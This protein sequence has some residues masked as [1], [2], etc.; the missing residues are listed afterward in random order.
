RR[1]SRIQGGCPAWRNRTV[2]V[3]VRS[4]ALSEA[5]MNQENPPCDEAGPD[6]GKPESRLEARLERMTRLARRVLDA[7]IAGLSLVEHGRQ[8]F[9]SVDG[10][11]TNDRNVMARLCE[12]TIQRQDVVLVR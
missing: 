7:E 12:R 11:G 8:W 4:S 10:I 5:P 9:T 6:Q 2:S 3:N 1:L